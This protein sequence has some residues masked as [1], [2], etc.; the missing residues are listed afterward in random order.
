MQQHWQI[1]CRESRRYLWY[2]SVG[3]LIAFIIYL[4]NLDAWR[5]EGEAG[6]G[7]LVALGY[8]LAVPG[9]IWVFYTT[10]F[11]IL[12]ALVHGQPYRLRWYFYVGMNGIGMIAG[13]WIGQRWQAFILG[14]PVEEGRFLPSVFF[15]G[16]LTLVFFFHFVWREAREEALRLRAVVAE[17]RYNALEQQM[18]PHFLFNA[19]NSLAELIESG[20]ERAA[21]VAYRLSELYRL[22]LAN[23]QAK[24]S[25][26]STEIEIVER[27]L[28]I[29][30]L[31]F[32]KRLSFS[33]AIPQE[34]RS[35]AAPSLVLQTLVE[36]AIK[37]G[38][39]KSLAGGRI[40]I[41][42]APTTDGRHVLS[43]SNTGAQLPAE[44]GAGT[45]IENTRARLALLYGER[46]D[47]RLRREAD[48][49]TI[50]SFTFSGAPID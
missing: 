37:H 50:A 4:F 5:A 25:P 21:E 9:T 6:K 29:E 38:V 7:L 14:R 24:T 34:C 26:L 45:G 22:I 16:L 43:V 31:R 8:G 33:F 36:N 49:R 19:L 3:P 1:F 15:G 39:A 41:G 44:V 35:L 11:A 12:S 2:L 47:F 23:S 28:E 30:Q 27:Y 40:E 48:G 46:S 20:E 18:R 13:L 17:A 42:I 10:F 32:G